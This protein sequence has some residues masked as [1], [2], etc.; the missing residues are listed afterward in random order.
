MPAFRPPVSAAVRRWSC[1]DTSG[2]RRSGTSS[3]CTATRLRRRL[4]SRARSAH[5]LGTTTTIA[6]RSDRERDRHL[7]GIPR[8][9]V[10][11]G[12]SLAGISVP[13][14]GGSRFDQARASQA[15]LLRGRPRLHRRLLQEAVR[16][17]LPSPRS[18]A[19]LRRRMFRHCLRRSV[20]ADPR[21]C[22]RPELQFLLQSYPLTSGRPAHRGVDGPLINLR[23][24][25]PSLDLRGYA[26]YLT[27]VA[28]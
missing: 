9:P 11:D 10:W 5:R 8:R 28:P 25:L 2:Q 16:D 19:A 24:P 14:R 26:V 7:D 13:A 18:G 21:A 15:A 1:P 17:P 4:S 20:V 22:T 3:S 6:V 12:P 23:H 27:P